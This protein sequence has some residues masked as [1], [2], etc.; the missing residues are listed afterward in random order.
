MHNQS[1]IIHLIRPDR[2]DFEEVSVEFFGLDYGKTLESRLILG[3]LY[4]D[5]DQTL[6]SL[7]FYTDS[8]LTFNRRILS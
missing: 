8:G 3:L 4:T 7:W 2:S 5:Y 6:I 1:L